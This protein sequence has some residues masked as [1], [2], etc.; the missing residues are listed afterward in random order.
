MNHARQNP[1]VRDG[2]AALVLGLSL[3]ATSA[4]ARAQPDGVTEAEQEDPVVREARLHFERGRE[5]ATMRRF[6][7][8]ADAFERSLAAVPRASTRFNLALCYYAL[9]HYVEALGELERFVSEADPV[10]DAES[11]VEAQQMI[12]HARSTVA[13]LTLELS[14]V[15]ANVQVDGAAL[16]GGA[17]RELRLN[18][19]T[20]VVRVTAEGHA[21]ALQEISLHEGADIRRAIELEVI[22]RPSHLAVAVRPPAGVDGDAI[23]RVDGTEVSGELEVAPG[24]HRVVVEHPGLLPFEREVTLEE[25][26]RLLVDAHLQRLP[27]PPTPLRRRPVLWV[28][29]GLAV[30]A[31]AIGLGFGLS[32][33]ERAPSGGTTGVVLRPANGSQGLVLE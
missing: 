29:V 25:G 14:P 1:T 3:L 31:G 28:G 6:G 21:A 11:L 33:R 2:L 8:A 22:R 10:A 24:T 30:V 27:D 15:N 9:A 12:G 32:G 18:P 23:V 19:G 13:Q 16:T 4:N 5:L 26:Q 17:V 20:H 7:E